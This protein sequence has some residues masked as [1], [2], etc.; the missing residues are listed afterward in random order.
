MFKHIIEKTPLKTMTPDILQDDEASA[1]P[2]EV[3]GLLDEG[4]L[5]GFIPN[6]LEGNMGS[7]QDT[8]HLGRLL[9]RRSLT[10]AIALGQT[11]L[12]SLPVWLYG[13]EEQKK[14]LV[15]IL[16]S[17]GLNCL[18]LTEEENGSDLA[19]TQVRDIKGV[20]SGKKWCINNAT[21][22]KALS[23][24]TK[25]ENDV[26][27]VYFVQ[28][29][30]KY[31][32]SFTNIPKILTLGIR[33][34]DISGIEFHQFS[35]E[36]SLLGRPGQGLEIILKTM[37]IS[38]LLCSSFSLGASDTILRRALEFSLERKL[39]GKEIIH[40]PAVSSKLLISYE[41]LLLIEAFSLMCARFVTMCPEVLSLYSA[42]SKYYVTKLADEIILSCTEVIGGRFYI[43]DSQYGI[44]QKIMRDHRV[45]SLFDGNSDVNIGIIA[46]QLK[47]ISELS[48]PKENVQ[49]IYQVKN[50]APHFTGDEK[51][52]L[53]TRGRDFI[54]EAQTYEKLLQDRA[55][56]F[57]K[58]NSIENIQS[59]E[60]LS[61]VEKYCELTLKANYE[62]FTHYN[63][64]SF[65]FKIDL[66]NLDLALPLEQLQKKC[67]FSHF[68]NKIND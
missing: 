67:L 22:G 44:A 24:L 38:R 57:K 1:F 25:N 21:K 7:I 18:A 48:S 45:V 19:L 37:Q 3:Q 43:R 31:S 46:G 63:K 64:E 8:L 58:I 65:D 20:I 2:R 54:W 56:L 23:V 66:E 6:H 35:Q 11:L 68:E 29:N 26:L 34:A 36:G 47:R 33:G 15:A 61:C 12:G 39:Y 42:V 32:G 55:E 59:P 30:K 5:D 60:M 52:R 27:N 10:T 62:L 13:N 51:L 40:I 50:P 4:I 28:K 17:G 41:K 53:T 9:S 16:I 49:E 14:S